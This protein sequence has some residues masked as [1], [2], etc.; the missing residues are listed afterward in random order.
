MNDDMTG[1]SQDVEMKLD[2]AYNAL[3]GNAVKKY[4]FE[5]LAA[6]HADR[7]DDFAAGHGGLNGMKK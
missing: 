2:R 6:K 3:Q 7:L 5:K 1:F 4:G